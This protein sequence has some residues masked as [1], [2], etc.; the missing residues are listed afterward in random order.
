MRRYVSWVL[1]VVALGLIAVAAVSAYADPYRI[2]AAACGSQDSAPRAALDRHVRLWK[3]HAVH[4]GCYAAVVLGS[5]RAEFGIDPEHAALRAAGPSF[6]LALPSAT[7]VESA[8][9]FEH[10]LTAGTLRRAVLAVDFLMF[11]PREAPEADFDPA[12]LLREDAT[13]WT[14]WQ[15]RAERARALISIDTLMASRLTLATREPAL[16]AYPYRA[17]GQRDASRQ[18]DNLRAAGGVRAAFARIARGYAAQV[19]GYDA[20]TWLDAHAAPWTAYRRMLALAHAHGVDLRVMISPAHASECQ[21]FDT[22]LGPAAL[23]AWK[24][25]LVALH[26]ELAR[27]HATTAMPLWDFSCANAATIEAVP[28][29]GDVERL[30]AGYWDLSHYR[31]EL[32]TR[33]LD[34]LFDMVPATW[35][36]R[37]Q[38]DTLEATLTE[39]AARQQAFARDA[40]ALLAD[41]G[42]TGEGDRR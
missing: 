1:G 33:A 13:T 21:V 10:A 7:L 35:G 40:A 14:R 25:S 23:R 8:A 37:L 4:G 34:E 6:N 18:P 30:M 31:A 11:D 29:L 16:I 20:G 27:E 19:Q 41:L 26:A 22:V 38:A 28:P 17:N 2:F 36:V 42:L 15:A 39:Q 9:Y 3:A 24:R 5:S 32:G 12:R